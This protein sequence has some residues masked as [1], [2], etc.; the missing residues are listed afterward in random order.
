MTL[1]SR[2]ALLNLIPD[3]RWVPHDIPNGEG[4]ERAHRS[5]WS[6]HL[7][8]KAKAQR[9]RDQPVQPSDVFKVGP[10]GF[11]MGRRRK[12]VLTLTGSHDPI[13][14]SRTNQQMQSSFFGKLPPEIRFMIYEYL[15]DE[16]E[17]IHLILGTKRKK[18][19]HFI[20]EE[21]HAEDAEDDHS[22]TFSDCS[23]KILV[24]GRQMKRLDP[25]LF[26]FIKA[27]RRT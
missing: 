7:S 13:L 4:S 22:N 5:L 10:N 2:N 27:C 21:S 25:G 16:S 24:G 20:C 12:S 14:D 3:V 26:S 1:L 18:Y 9:A 23:C 19:Q 15:F 17:T 11:Q 8:G 6:R